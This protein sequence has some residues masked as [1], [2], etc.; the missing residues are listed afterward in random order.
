MKTSMAIVWVMAVV[1]GSNSKSISLGIITIVG[2]GLA[3]ILATNGN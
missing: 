3:V 1:V 2:Y